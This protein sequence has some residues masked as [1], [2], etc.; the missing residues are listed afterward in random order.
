L[1]RKVKYV[2]VGRSTSRLL[3]VENEGDEGI[4]RMGEK[5][6]LEGGSEIVGGVCVSSAM[7]PSLDARPRLSPR[8]T[9]PFLFFFPLYILFF[10]FLSLH[11]SSKI[12]FHLPVTNVKQGGQPSALIHDVHPSMH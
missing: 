5:Q 10:S 4:E 9:S 7:R 8:L 11:Y 3:A 6:A 2:G 12:A 1:R